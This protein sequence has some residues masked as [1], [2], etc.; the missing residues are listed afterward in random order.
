[1]T[2]KLKIHLLKDREASEA[3]LLAA[4]K[5]VFS[6]NG[7]NGATTRDIAKK[8]ELNISLI[9]R[10]FESKHGLFLAVIK[11]QNQQFRNVNLS[12]PPQETIT[13]ELLNFAK[14]IIYEFFCDSA[15]VKIV[16][17][18]FFSDEKF[19]KDFRTLFPQKSSHPEFEKRLHDLIK[20]KKMTESASASE[21]AFEFETIVFGMGLLNI[22]V[23]GTSTQAAYKEI[24][25]F[26]KRYSSSLVAKK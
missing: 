9:N 19:V 16:M 20:K 7:F 2:K 15:F 1:M 11:N 6:K 26:V 5:E 10:Y 14:A 17:G 18:Q 4:A 22:I 12:Y 13:L 25:N 21:I 8:A 24:E 23:H 3:R